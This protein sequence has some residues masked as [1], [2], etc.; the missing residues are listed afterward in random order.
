MR[1]AWTWTCW[2]VSWGMKWGGV[3][4]GGFAWQFLVLVVACAPA[5]STPTAGDGGTVDGSLDVVGDAT[6]DSAKEAGPPL[7]LACWG[8]AR[9]PE[10]NLA[11]GTQVKALRAALEDALTMSWSPLD[12]LATGLA[13]SGADG[14]VL[15]TYGGTFNTIVPALTPSEQTALR[16]FV[17]AGHFAILLLDNDGYGGPIDP[18]NDSLARPFGIDP[19]GTLVP[20]GG[21]AEVTPVALDGGVHP[22]FAGVP[23][24]VQYFPGWLDVAPDAGAS[25]TIVATNASGAAVDV[26]EKGT[27]GPGSGVVIVFSD[28]GSFTDD[29]PGGLTPAAQK[30]LVQAVRYAAEK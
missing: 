3:V 25:P 7:R 23:S 10:Y 16:A 5:P 9:A 24:M 13:T 6:S 19:T 17:D 21:F 11:N 14:I 22:I 4:R 29:V 28:T 26:F 2:A 8:A 27:L 20:D 12:S 18:Y 30:V 15:T 1:N